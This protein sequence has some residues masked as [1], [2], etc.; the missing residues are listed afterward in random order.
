MPSPKL[1]PV[2][3]SAEERS[4]L[5]AWT[6]RRKT[7][8]ALSARSQI[9]LACAAGGSI[10]AVA[11]QLGVSRDMVSKWRSRFLRDRLEGL[12]SRGRGGP[13]RLPMSRWSG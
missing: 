1:A 2:V 6:R 4:A 7:S 8:Q 3:L 11:A 5:E 13:A 9:V 12:M 10:G